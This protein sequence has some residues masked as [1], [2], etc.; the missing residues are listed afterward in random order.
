MSDTLIK[1]YFWVT[2]YGSCLFSYYNEP[3]ILKRLVLVVILWIA[4]ALFGLL[5]IAISALYD[6]LFFPAKRFELINKRT[7]PILAFGIFYNYVF[8]AFG[9]VMAL[10]MVAM[11]II[12]I[13]KAGT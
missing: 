12:G 5:I 7:I 6:Y 11:G 9:A 13:Y 2:L 3:E 1:I 10:R 8:L 4:A